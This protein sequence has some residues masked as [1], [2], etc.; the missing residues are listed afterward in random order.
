MNIPC[1]ATKL[2]RSNFTLVLL[3]RLFI[4]IETDSAKYCPKILRNV[5][6]S[7][8]DL[9]EPGRDVLEPGGTAPHL[10]PQAGQTAQ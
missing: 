1:T 8:T 9:V 2:H 5:T 3:S 6:N 4:P 7:W 10:L